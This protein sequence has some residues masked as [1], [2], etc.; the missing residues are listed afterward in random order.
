[1]KV[2]RDSKHKSNKVT[3]VV[4][5][6]SICSVAFSATIE[7]T[8]KEE[9]L[10]WRWNYSWAWK[11]FIT[12]VKFLSTSL[13]KF[14]VLTVEVLELMIQITL[15]LVLPV[16]VKDTSSEDNKSLLATT[17]NSNRLV[18]SV[19]VKV[20]PL[21]LNATSARVQRLF[22]DLMRCPSSLKRVLAMDKLLNST[23][24]VMNTLT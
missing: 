11:I 7:E 9:V 22:L 13:N 15:R 14:S 12:A 8:L 6:F 18:K 10:N 20:R 16:M 24:V 17:N 4:V 19:V 2:W 3:K 21:L 23:V 5:I 1:M